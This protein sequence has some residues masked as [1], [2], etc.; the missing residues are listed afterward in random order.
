MSHDLQRQVKT[1]EVLRQ[2]KWSGTAE[3][4]CSRA[5]ITKECKG[6]HTRHS[7][8]YQTKGIVSHVGLCR[9]C[10]M[11]CGVKNCNLHHTT[12]A[13]PQPPVSVGCLLTQKASQGR[14]ARSK[15]LP[16]HTLE[17]AWWQL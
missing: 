15:H 6:Q 14:A 13:L 4:A 5:Y 12:A 16:A 3:V 10:L 2:H 7:A 17:T 11:K 8:V 1:A 9:H